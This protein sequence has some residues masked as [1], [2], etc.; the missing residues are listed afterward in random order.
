MNQSNA[1]T[2]LFVP[3]MI[4]VVFQILATSQSR[5]V[6]NQLRRNHQTLR[7]IEHHTRAT[8]KSVEAMCRD[9]VTPPSAC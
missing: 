3:L 5:E 4:L 9:A 2:W 1:L 7:N 6:P 8:A